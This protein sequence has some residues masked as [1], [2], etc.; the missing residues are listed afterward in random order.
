MDQTCVRMLQS[1]WG[2]TIPNNKMNNNLIKLIDKHCR[3]AKV[4]AMELY[5]AIGIK[6]TNLLIQ[7]IGERAPTKGL[8]LKELETLLAKLEQS[9]RL[10]SNDTDSLSNDM[11]QVYKLPKLSIPQNCSKNYCKNGRCITSLAQTVVA[12]AVN[13]E[14]K[15]AADRIV[16][17]CVAS[18]L[19]AQGYNVGTLLVD[20]KPID[21][22]QHCQPL[23][24]NW[25][26]VE[27]VIDLWKGETV[28]LN[29]G[30]SLVLLDNPDRPIVPDN[31]KIYFEA[32]HEGSYH[33]TSFHAPGPI[34]TLNIHDKDDTLSYLPKLPKQYHRDFLHLI[35]RWIALDKYLKQVEI[36][37][38]NTVLE[39]R[40]TIL[41]RAC[42]GVADENRLFKAISDT[43]IDKA[44][45][46]VTDPVCRVVFEAWKKSASNSELFLECLEGGKVS[47]DKVTSI[48]N[49][50]L[51]LNT[52]ARENLQRELQAQ[53]CKQ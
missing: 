44:L 53:L 21:W 18:H 16:A 3:G 14:E 47:F 27:G 24:I 28:I 43:I 45:S 10:E 2:V 51:T 34:L 1:Y 39:D 32:D 35:R 25:N 26:N 9:E 50:Q 46:H 36:N 37:N 6:D 4:T 7:L 30:D 49:R 22:S 15:K 29:S 23:T 38:L 20:C 33:F 48:I 8:S 19:K 40:Q 13:D 41:G 12:A 42:R 17:H 5:K 11:L 31:S 52:K